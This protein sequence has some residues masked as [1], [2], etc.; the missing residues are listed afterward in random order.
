MS[1]K[2]IIHNNGFK[3]IKDCECFTR[4]II[5]ELGIT[6]I[7]KNDDK[8][9]Y[10]R[11]LIKYH[12]NY[13]N[14]FNSEIIKFGIQINNSNNLP[15]EMYIIDCNE[16]KDTFSWIDCCKNINMNNKNK[17]KIIKDEN[18]I[19][20]IKAMRYT[21]YPETNS[22]KISKKIY[23]TN[24]LMCNICNKIDDFKKFD[25]DHLSPSFKN[26]SDNFLKTRNDIPV[27]FNKCS[28]NKT[29]IFTENDEIFKNDWLNY[30]NNNA[31]YQILCKS[32]NSKKG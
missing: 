17:N 30:H 18:K 9:Y 16:N 12:P 5:K 13:N 23:R 32:C 1:F 4:E 27:I 25:V 10:F 7:D 14:K 6:E 28:V 21:I 29:M 15:C 3:T 11:E 22:F 24:N 19:N 8:F 31:T 2:Y 26:I 20:L